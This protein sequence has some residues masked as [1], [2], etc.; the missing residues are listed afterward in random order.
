MLYS[1]SHI[2]LWFVPLTRV[3]C[4]MNSEEL[5]VNVVDFVPESSSD[6]IL[7]LVKRANKQLK[8][9]PIAGRELNVK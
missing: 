2:R 6:T 7:T 8:E 9:I 5:T 3:N 4:E 1:M